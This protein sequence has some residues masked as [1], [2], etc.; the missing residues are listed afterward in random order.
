[1]DQD[2]ANE[3]NETIHTARQSCE[4]RGEGLKPRHVYLEGATECVC[5]R[6]PNLELQRMK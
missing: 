3:A 4:D 1:M 2:T 5:K 6:G